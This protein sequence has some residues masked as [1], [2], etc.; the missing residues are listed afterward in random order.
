MCRKVLLAFCFLVFAMCTNRSYAQEE[1]INEEQSAEV[2]LEEYTDEFQ[3]LFFEALKQK[4]IQNYDRATNL[5][6]KCRQLQPV[7]SVIDHELA[8][9]YALDNKLTTAGQYAL[10]A[11]NSEPDNYWYLNTLVSI[12]GQQRNTIESVK[13][14]IAFDNLQLKRNLALIYF[15]DNKLQ[16]SLSVLKTL[17]NSN[18]KEVLTSKIKDSLYN[19]GVREKAVDTTPLEQEQGPLG[20]FKTQIAALMEEG[21]YMS[22]EKLSA[23]ALEAYPLQPYFYYVNG[24][25]KRYNNKP[26]EAIEV[27]Q[28]ALDYLIDDNEL[29]NKIYRELADAYKA[30]GNTSKANEYLNKIKP[31]S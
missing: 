31:G 11:I 17:D 23:E 8:K 18:F 14:K 22:L 6:L 13:E 9:T 7:N 10:N 2:F 1:E 27:L 16:E 4:G 15:K 12:L 3:E 21:S 24:L 28:T 26:N 20:Q 19:R 25:A 30:L 5:L 29:A